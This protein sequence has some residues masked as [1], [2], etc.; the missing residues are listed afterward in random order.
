MPIK[1]GAGKQ[2]QNQMKTASPSPALPRRLSLNPPFPTTRPPFPPKRHRVT[3]N[4]AARSPQ[5]LVSA[6]PS[7]SCHSPAPA[8]APRPQ[9]RPEKLLLPGLLSRGLSFCQEPA[10]AWAPLHGLQL[11][12]GAVEGRLRV[13][14]LVAGSSSRHPFHR[15]TGYLR[16][17]GR[18]P[19]GRNH[20]VPPPCSSR[21]TYSRLSM[22]M[23]RGLGNIS[24]DGDST[25]S[26]GSL[27]R[28]SSPAQHPLHFPL[29]NCMR[30]LSAHL[31][32]LPRC[33]RI[34]ARP[35]GLS[36][37]PPS[38]V[39]SANLLRVCSAPSSRPLI[40][41]DVEQD[42]TQYRPLGDTTSYWPPPRL[43]AT[44]QH[45]LGPAVQPLFSPPHCQLIQS[46]SLQVT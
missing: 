6:A 15:I 28:C 4:G 42:R 32:S 17:A 35:P 14:V 39:S 5:H 12:G 10:L 13:T 41:E 43:G 46:S 3:G 27:C 29:L 44:E 18:S 36:A 16:L 21:A 7:S 22:T 2:Q 1:K 40:K 19:G 33:L 26:L 25:G 9:L 34:A 45:P 38:L 20:R 31:S 8:W 23:S 24:R 37:T 11:P 30:S